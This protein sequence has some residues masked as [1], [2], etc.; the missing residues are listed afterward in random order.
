M[1]AIAICGQVIVLFAISG[2]GKICV[3]L[4]GFLLDH[5]TLALPG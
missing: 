2:I 4:F 3:C 1:W 5:C